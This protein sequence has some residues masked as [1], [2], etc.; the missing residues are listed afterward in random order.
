[1]AKI[2]ILVVED[3][4][5][6]RDML[7]LV[8]E[9]AGFK[10]RP[11]MNVQ[12]ALQEIEQHLPDLILLDWMLPGISGVDWAKRLRRDAAYSD[13]PIIL[14]TA[15]S[16]EEDKVLGLDSGADD[17]ITKPFSPRELIARINAVLRRF[18]KGEKPGLIKVGSILLNP[19]EHKVEID[20]K[21][22]GLSPTE[23]R[24]LEFF[25][26]HP[27][28]VY[29]RGQLLDRVWGRDAY[30]EERTVDV[31]IRRLRKILAEYGCDTM[32]ETVRGFGYRL[33]A[34]IQP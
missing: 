32:I 10:V 13:I 14:L 19:E 34:P 2:D 15:R 7:Q 30:I 1:M 22:I 5:A 12:A 25:L 9:Q 16:E 4:A 33:T 17:Y 23:Y 18:G 28:K 8:L 26:I 21:P 31:H 29:S 6:I 24:L 11:A 20:G 27:D 3:E